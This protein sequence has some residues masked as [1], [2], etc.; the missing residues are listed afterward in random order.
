M[1]KLNG[2]STMKVTMPQR[3]AT[4]TDHLPKGL[5]HW[6]GFGASGG[7]A[8]VTDVTILK[9]LALTTI[10]PVNGARILSIAVAMVAGWL[11]HRRFTFN[12]QTPPSLAEFIRYAG[13]AWVAAA[14]NYAVFIA[15]LWA[16][17]TLEPIIAAALSA[18]VAMVAGYLGMRF[19]AFRKP[20]TPT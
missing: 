11:A 15:I 6:L 1:A 18:G 20:P 16:R 9:L 17:P 12:V 19:A 8:F 4:T 13:V 5:R 3:Q 7:I 10:I 14:I 2:V